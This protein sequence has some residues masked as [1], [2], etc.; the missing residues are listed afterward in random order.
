MTLKMQISIRPTRPMLTKFL[1]HVEKSLPLLTR[2]SIGVALFFEDVRFHTGDRLNFGEEFG[3][4]ELTLKIPVF[5]S[6]T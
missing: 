4:W 5:V 3:V 1:C 6:V 2:P